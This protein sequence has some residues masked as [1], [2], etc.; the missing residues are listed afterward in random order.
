MPRNT[1]GVRDTPNSF[2]SFDSP[3][4]LNNPKSPKS[5]NNPKSSNNPKSPKSL[6]NPKSSNNPKSPKDTLNSPKD[7]LNNSSKGKAL[8]LYLYYSSITCKLKKGGVKSSVVKSASIDKF[9]AAVKSVIKKNRTKLKLLKERVNYNQIIRNLIIDYLDQ[10]EDSH[11]LRAQYVKLWNKLFKNSKQLIN[12]FRNST[13]TELIHYFRTI[14][15]NK[16]LISY[17]IILLNFWTKNGDRYIKSV[18]RQS[19]EYTLDSTLA[20]KIDFIVNSC[21]TYLGYNP[22]YCPDIVKYV[23]PLDSPTKYCVLLTLL[24]NYYYLEIIQANYK[25]KSGFKLYFGTNRDVI[26]SITTANF[27]IPQSASFNMEVACEFLNGDNAI[28]AM[29][30]FNPSNSLERMLYIPVAIDS[31]SQYSTENETLFIPVKTFGDTITTMPKITYQVTIRSINRALNHAMQHAD[32][33]SVI[34]L[35]PS[36]PTDVLELSIVDIPQIIQEADF[37][38]SGDIFDEDFDD[39]FGIP[40]IPTAG[41]C[42]KCNKYNKTKKK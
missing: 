7:T 41:G 28:L 36:Q 17:Y 42:N 3:K 11:R 5:L 39:V 25:P 34:P 26:N 38:L 16:L 21:W 32:D 18:L 2:Q 27:L 13:L 30:N 35:Y 1:K 8:L 10:Q 23:D 12:Q 9:T 24:T 37:D 15:P 33:S 29:Y 14:T 31:I 20:Q 6:N 40:T 4:S 19:E 22:N